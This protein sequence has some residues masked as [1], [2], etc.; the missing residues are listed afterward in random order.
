MKRK[1]TAVILSLFILV[2]FQGISGLIGGF[3]L[4]AD[5]SGASLQIPIE[6][7]EGSP[8]HNYL[9]PGIIL[10][11]ILG[12]APVIIG[13]GLWKE[14]QWAWVGSFL[15]GIALVIWIIVEI[16]VIGYQPSPPLQLIYG[17]VGICI[18]FFVNLPGVKQF[19]SN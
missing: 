12:V 9:L 2:L 3:G 18:L 17:L 15:L 19:Y 11:L 7:L 6:W 13:F 1:K 5:P 16:I 10:F 14:K 4:I 8:F